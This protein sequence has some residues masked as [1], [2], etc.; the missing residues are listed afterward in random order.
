MKKIFYLALFVAVVAVATPIIANANGG[1]WI[2]PPNIE[3]SQTDQNAI[4]AWNGQEEILILSTNWEKSASSSP[5]TLLKVVPLPSEPSEIKEGKTEIFDKLVKILNE[6]IDALR[7]ANTGKSF[8]PERV[9]LPME[10]GVEIVFQKTIGAHDVTV[11]KVN[12]EE[13][14][15]KWIDDFSA[16]KN[17]GGKQ[18]SAEFKN[19]LLNYLKR[20]IKYFIFDIANLDET[21]TTIKPLIYKFKSDYFYFP[22]LVSGISEINDSQTKVNLFLIF[23]K[24][25][26]LPQRIW[27]G[28]YNY[29]ID[30]RETD[31]GLT[32]N[33][34][35]DISSGLADLFGAKDVL[36]RQFGLNGKL[37]EINKD[38]MLFPQLLTNNLKIGIRGNDVKIL[39]QLLINEGLWESP[40]GATGY[41]GPVTKKAVMKFQGQYKMQILEPL[42]LTSPT[43]FFGPYTRK[44]LNENVFIDV[45]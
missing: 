19:G 4:I 42:G 24:T 13:D 7:A 29:W 30:D 26:K 2:W 44:Y 17:L 21:K 36:V 27:Q 16:T 33:E 45:K 28:S 31:I 40:A 18:I 10:P 11:V 23:N 43:G 25:T 20:D 12:K 37:S 6:K 41:F 3:V 1:V 32:N 14:F 15:S 39:Q 35:K 22:M 38:L 5:A 9:A 8:G 34:L